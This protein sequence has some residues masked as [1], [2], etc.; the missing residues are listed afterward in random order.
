M[1]I[2]KS[3]RECTVIM[4]AHRIHILL[5]FDRVAVLDSGRVVEVGQPLE[6][7]LKPHGGFSKLLDLES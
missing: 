7:M 4:V 2:R 1:V 6:L 3:F 5:D